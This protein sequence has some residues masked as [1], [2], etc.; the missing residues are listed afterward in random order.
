ME[1]IE[2]QKLEP[3][4]VLETSNN[5]NTVIENIPETEALVGDKKNICI[6]NTPDTDTMKDSSSAC[7]CCTQKNWISSRFPGSRFAGFLNFCWENM[8]DF[9][10]ALAMNGEERIHQ[11]PLNENNFSPKIKKCL[12]SLEGPRRD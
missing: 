1:N 10:E 5:D 9:V 11:D 7:Q 4:N 6:S 12:V 2:I 3:P 8:K